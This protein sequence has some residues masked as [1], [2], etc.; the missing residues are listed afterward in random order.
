MLE[1]LIIGDSIAA[2][3]AQ[4]RPECVSHATV[5]ITSRKWVDKNINKDLTAKT[6]IISLGSNDDQ[7]I[8]TIAELYTVRNFVRAE[9]V[10]WIVPA[11]KPAKQEDVKSTA[12]MFRDAAIEI[13]SISKDNVHPTAKGY[14]EL[15]VQTK[16]Y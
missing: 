6:V 11:T 4:H 1:C 9:K 10:V 2:G 5:G 7:H 8:N 13:G 14:K 3:V 15:A 16:G 12:I